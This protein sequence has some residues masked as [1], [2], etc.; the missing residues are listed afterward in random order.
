MVV[1]VLPQL[2]NIAGIQPAAAQSTNSRDTSQQ[3][4]ATIPDLPR[5]NQYISKD[6]GKVATDNTLVSRMINYHYYQ[7]GRAP[8]YRFDWKLTMADYL[9]ANEIMYDSAY[10]GH[11]TLRQNPL[12]GDRAAIKKLNRHQRNVLVQTLV[13]IFSSSQ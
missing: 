10:P 2:S 4:Y 12:A 8:N 9:G 7:K 13:N 11:D 6:N 1:S 3:V 5:E